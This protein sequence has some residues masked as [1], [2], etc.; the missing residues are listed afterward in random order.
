MDTCCHYFVSSSGIIERM[1]FT[2][3]D[4]LVLTHVMV[5]NLPF[6]RLMTNRCGNIKAWRYFCSH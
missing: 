6:D 3:D 4:H 2:D 5:D 1:D